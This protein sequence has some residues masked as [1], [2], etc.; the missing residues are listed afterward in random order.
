VALM[1]VGSLRG[2]PAT[3]HHLEPLFAPG[4]SPWTSILVV[5][6][7][8]PWAY[9]GF[10]TIPQAA[11]EIGFPPERA[12]GLMYKAILLAGLMYVVVLLSTALAFPWTERVYPRVPVW[13]TGESIRATMG[14]FG[15]T[16]LM[17][18]VTMGILTGI[19]GFFI[20]TSRL[21]LCMGRARVLPPWFAR[22]HPKYRTPS[23][24]I[25]FIMFV[26][27]LAPWFGRQAIIWIVNM[28]ALG[29][30]LGYGYT[31]FAAHRLGAGT[32][33]VRNRWMFRVGGVFSVSVIGLLTVPGSPA[34]LD[35]PSWIAL[36]VW[37]LMGA[38]FYLMQAEEYRGIPSRE[39]DRL[40]LDV[41]RPGAE[42]EIPR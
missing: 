34:A 38:M 15:V 23:N 9:M 39:L 19:N 31:S 7:I 30:A 10:D 41:V 11:E 13:A 42:E 2:V 3:V 21:L 18:G 5:L 24:A 32:S 20:A 33:E 22:V 14:D 35:M 25:L 40:I 4:K 17:L 6:A 12:T 37:A 26:S 1:A 8:S 36:G 28:S 29:M 16:V 27:L